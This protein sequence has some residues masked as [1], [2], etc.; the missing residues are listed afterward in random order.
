MG[1][2]FIATARTYSFS[3]AGHSTV[4]ANGLTMDECIINAEKFLIQHPGE[5]TKLID[6]YEAKQVAYKSSEWQDLRQNQNVTYNFTDLMKTYI[7][8]KESSVLAKKI[9][10]L[11][12]ETKLNMIWPIGASI[13]CGILMFVN[14]K[15][16]YFAWFMAISLV[17]CI[18]SIFE[19]YKEYKYKLYKLNR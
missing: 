2:Y 5:F 9:A 18:A 15:I 1:E 6:V 10:E 11:K 12:C 8:R 19:K 4:I 7:K 16:D 17:F 3:V 14:H 13:T